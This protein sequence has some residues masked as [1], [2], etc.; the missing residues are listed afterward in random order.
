M[1]KE[2]CLGYG[3]EVLNISEGGM[4]GR[5]GNTY[6]EQKYQPNTDDLHESTF[7]HLHLGRFVAGAM[8]KYLW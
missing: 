2:I 5:A 1:I 8:S 6:M 7:G 4:T 3:I